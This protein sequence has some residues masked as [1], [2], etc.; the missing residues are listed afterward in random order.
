MNDERERGRER[1]G[2]RGSE[3]ARERGRECVV[4]IEGCVVVC[5]NA[6][7]G[8]VLKDLFMTSYFWCCRLQQCRAREGPE[9]LVYD[10]LLLV[11]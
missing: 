8:K 7:H 1:G 3:G 9:G 4:V 6:E 10:V 2:E 11:L 5:S